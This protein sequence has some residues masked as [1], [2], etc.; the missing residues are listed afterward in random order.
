MFYV[1][2]LKLKW[3][4]VFRSPVPVD[5]HYKRL[6][7]ELFHLYTDLQAL[8]EIE[9]RLTPQQREQFNAFFDECQS[10]C[11]FIFGEDIIASVRRLGLMAFRIAMVLTILR[12]LET[13]DMSKVQ[14][15]SD[16]DFNSAITM[17]RV[18]LAHSARIFSFLP[19]HHVINISNVDIESKQQLLFDNLPEKFDRK[20]FISVGKQAGIPVS[21][22]ERIVKYFCDSNKIQ[23][24][25]RGQYQKVVQEQ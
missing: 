10:E 4:D 21:T 9:F 19:T 3:R 13:G 15:C 25:N 24:Y 6:S 22:A 1:I 12:I 20:T 5:S 17:V 23:R 8:K 18:I 2:E 11:D 7:D 16:D 14:T